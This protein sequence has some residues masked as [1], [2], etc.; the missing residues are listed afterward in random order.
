MQ[1]GNC[2]QRGRGKQTLLQ[3][4]KRINKETKIIINMA[5]A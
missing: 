3:T 4:N 2:Q 1:T 5:K